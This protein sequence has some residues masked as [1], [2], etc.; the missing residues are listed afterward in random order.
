MTARL[1]ASAARLFFCITLLIPLLGLGQNTLP[2]D[3]S[4]YLVN[5]TSGGSQ[6]ERLIPDASTG[7]I[8]ASTIPLSEPRRKITCLGY[9][10]SDQYLYALDFDTYDLLRIDSKGQIEVLGVP[11]NLDTKLKYHAGHVTP[12]G[13]SLSI[14]GRDPAT[15]FDKIIYNINI[16]GPPYFASSQALISALP[17]RLNDL[18][19]HPSL[20]VTYS[21]D[22]KGKRLVDVGG[23]LVSTFNYPVT[24]EYLSALYFD[25]TGNLYAYGNP[26]AEDDAQTH[27]YVDRRTGK[28]RSLGKGYQ[29]RESDGCSCPYSLDFGMKITPT[30][31]LPCSEITI[32][33]TFFNATGA[34]WQDLVFRDSFPAGVIIKAIEKNSANLSTIVGGVGSSVFRLINMNLIL[35]SNTIRLK[36][37]V[38]DLPPGKYSAQAALQFL[39]ALYGEPLVSDNLLSVQAR[40]S[41]F[42]NVVEPKSLKLSSN[43]RF[44]CNGDTAYVEAP[45]EA[46]NYQWSDGSTGKTLVTTRNGRY[47]LLAKTP[48][49]DYVDTIEIGERPAALKIGIQAPDRLESGDQIALAY[50][51]TSKGPFVESWSTS[52]GL[53]LSCKDC[54]SP[55]L[56]ALSSG[57][58]YLQVRNAQGCTALDS[59]SI[60]VVPLRKVYIPNAFSPNGDQLNDQFYV[61]GRDGG[62]I[63]QWHIKDRWG[64]LIFEKKDIRI[65][66]PSQ[67]WDG[68]FRGQRCAAGTFLYEIEIEFPD[69]VRKQFKGEVKLL[70]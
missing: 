45:L 62:Q 41:A 43:L 5:F 46:L 69:G 6:L 28:M 44:S 17:V 4:F 49:L 63:V 24:S 66:D 31:V 10:V 50:N 57:T 59:A 55:G 18:A 22:A 26:I 67:G 16:Q 70:R 56:S 8:I 42:F 2:C 68:T 37:W 35:E 36:A 60:E 39:P 9:S 21:F 32:E 58:V 47:S 34:N 25:K 15:Q 11:A 51:A 3:G 53:E 13:R 54:A 33:Y 40:D 29:G 30:Q 61:Q 14:I 52:T 7:K 38:D 23:G 65:N 64:N 27:F 12:L 48:C 19:T 1:N 20:G